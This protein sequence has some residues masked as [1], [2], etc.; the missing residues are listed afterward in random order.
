MADTQ[1]DEI[2][3]ILFTTGSTGPAKGVFYTHGVFD[4]QVRNIRTQFGITPDEIDLPTFPL[5][6]LFDPALGMTA[7]IPDMDPTKPA[8][9]IRKR[10]SKPSSTTASPTCSPPLPCS[11]AW[12]AMARKRASNCPP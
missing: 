5:F 6:A 2:A 8:R 9:S 7:I 1:A 11:T 4:A 3:A 10:S 12:A